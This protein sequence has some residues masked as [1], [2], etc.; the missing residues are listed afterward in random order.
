MPT[1]Y[2]MSQDHVP[3]LN[4]PFCK[5]KSAQLAFCFYVPMLLWNGMSENVKL[6][7][8]LKVFEIC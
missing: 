2:S 6:V 3:L 4:L 5:S 7:T 1:L 8:S